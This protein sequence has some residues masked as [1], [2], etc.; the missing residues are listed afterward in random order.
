MEWTLTIADLVE[1]YKSLKSEAVGAVELC[2]ET[3]KFLYACRLNE[4]RIFPFVEQADSFLK[5]YI[6]EE[7]KLRGECGED[8]EGI[9]KLKEGL[10]KLFVLHRDSFA[11]RDEVIAQAPEGLSLFMVDFENVPKLPWKVVEPLMEFI[12][13]P[14]QEDSRDD[15]EKHVETGSVVPV[16]PAA[17]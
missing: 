10:K 17:V 2:P 13:P 7:Q 1:M 11:A 16:A 15:E 8:G 4:K 14:K 5:E 3:S 9:K 6:E 12:R